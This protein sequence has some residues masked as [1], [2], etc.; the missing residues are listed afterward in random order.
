MR[1]DDELLAAYQDELAHLRLQGEQF[2]RR[3]PQVAAQLGLGAGPAA[4]PHI[5]R[6]IEANAF[7]A[8]RVQRDL[9]R[10]QPV[11]AASLLEQLAPSLAQPL[12]ALTVARLQPD[13]AQGKVTAGLSVPAH[14]LLLAR[15]PAPASAEEADALDGGEPPLRWRTAWDLTL[16]PLHLDAVQW[17]DGHELRLRLRAEPGTELRELALQQLSLHLSAGDAASPVLY[18]ALA[19]GLRH[20]AL[21]GADGRRLPLAPHQL[22]PDGLAPEQAL[23]PRAPQTPPGLGL[24]QEQLAFAA[25]GLFFRLEGLAAVVPRLGP[26]EHAWLCLGLDR[27]HASHPALARVG[28]EAVRLNCVPV[29]NLFAQAGEPLRLDGRQHEWRLVGSHRHEAAV[30]VHSVLAVALDRLDGQPPQPLPP[31]GAHPGP[32]GLPCWSLRRDRAARAELPGSDVWLALTEDQVPETARLLHT[33]LLCTNRHRAQ[34]LPA[35]A[36]LVA[37]GV[38]SALH[39]RTLYAPSPAQDAPVAGEQLWRLVGLL[40]LQHASLVPGTV[41][42]TADGAASTDQE[43][44]VAPLRSLLQLL[45]GGQA[46]ALAPLQG[47]RALRARPGV[48]RLPGPAW[49][50]LVRGTELELEVDRNAFTGSSPLLLGA[51]LARFL[52]LTTT[53]NT[54]V[55]LSLR[56]G[57]EIW[58]PWPPMSGQQPLL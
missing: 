27:R 33:R 49:R 44:S 25:R 53:T 1:A 47:L 56:Q 30:E 41:P 54:F 6:L 50:G 43:A 42:A 55:R 10:L 4:D 36:R 40:R 2:A 57:D 28:P 15:P 32:T 3:H 45:A 23:L 20:L 12:P 24:L 35:G 39:I 58:T 37:E 7:L 13:P 21:I 19:C 29:V 11:L 31:L 14:T 48:A 22:V 34:Q 16:W 52:A 5:E 26:G 17:V 38:S 51:A 46:R 18:E 9:R 8:A